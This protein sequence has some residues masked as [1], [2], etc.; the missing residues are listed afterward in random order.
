MNID[1]LE[2]E[3]KKVDYLERLANRRHFWTIHTAVLSALALKD[4]ELTNKCNGIEK[5]EWK[6]FSVIKNQQKVT[7]KTAIENDA[8]NSTGDIN[9]CLSLGFFSF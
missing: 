1:H 2:V 5:H 6:H 8:V 4:C 9:W 3:R 7:V